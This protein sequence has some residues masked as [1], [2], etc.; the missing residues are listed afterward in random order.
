MVKEFREGSSVSLI[1][2]YGS[3][4]FFSAF[5]L[6]QI[7][8]IIGKILLPW[9]GGSASVWITC[10]LFFQSFLLLGYLYAHWSTRFL[11]PIAQGIIHLCLLGASV[12]VLSITPSS[13]WK[14][15][16]SENPAWLVF[17]LLVGST[18]LPYFLLST[19]G[20]LAQA[21][22]AREIPGRLPYR[23]FALSN[24]A[25]LIGLL[26]Y[27]VLFEPYLTTH[28][29][30]LTWSMVF[31]CFVALCGILTC[32]QMFVQ[33]RIED[34]FENAAT[35][36]SDYG[37]LLLWMALAACP[38]V[39]LMAV[40]SH[41]TQNIA[42]IPF[43]WVAPL[44]LY[45]LSFILCFERDG[46]YRRVWYVPLLMVGLFGL[47]Y[48][49]ISSGGKIAVWFSIPLCS[50]TLFFACM[51][52]HGELAKQKPLPQFLT[53]FYLMV[54]LGGVVGGFFVAVVAPHFFNSD[55]ELTIG[56][57]ATVALVIGILYR[58]S[59]CRLHQIQKGRG[60]RAITVLP[61]VLAI[62]LGY[63]AWETVEH[64]RVL[65]RNFYGTLAVRDI[66]QGDDAQRELRHGGTIHGRQFLTEKRTLWPITYY[67]T[68]S[69]GGMA[70]LH[71]R[72]GSPQ[73]VGIIGL[74]A[75][76]LAAYARQRDYYRFYEIN[77]L[78]IQFARKEFSFLSHSGAGVEIIQ[79]DARLS[80]EREPSQQFDVLLVDA[81][82]G[83]SIPIHLLTGEAFA[84]YF[85]HLKPEGILAVHVSHRHL[86]LA[87]IVKMAADSYSK[88]ARLVISEAEKD[89]GT[90]PAHWVLVTNRQGFFSSERLKDAVRPIEVRLGLRP[91]TDDFSSILP[92]LGR[93]R[94]TPEKAGK[95]HGTQEPF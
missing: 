86:N 46:W 11:G 25:S 45:L 52:C 74:G 36:V 5:L 26:T 34:S 39:L 95:R 76:T 29:Q 40:T 77:P 2:L 75:G 41:L 73:R 12:T 63:R 93:P 90:L 14:P 1:L 17:G 85:Q 4:I 18:G 55:Y 31:V 48:D 83:H 81:F 69:G 33:R 30:S 61:A 71:E 80:L 32:R 59:S 58:D 49:L 37:L 21:W 57:L 24:F 50:A 89:K 65:T 16:G 68:N 54:A 91:W 82:S 44:S 13:A 60:W 72:N 78:V 79:G 10:L 51:V 28:L 19:T 47:A 43:L 94:E 67:G 92:V 35:Q 23:L 8:P 20:P 87:P 53:S 56:I 6:F 15:A 27:P 3:T 84:L 66:G 38:S 88:E 9:F 7:Q 62:T 42:P 70:I 22:F 64:S